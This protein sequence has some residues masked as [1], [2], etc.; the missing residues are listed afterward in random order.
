MDNWKTFR[1][2]AWLGWQTESNW[3]DPFLFA[4]YS[5]IRPIAVTLLVVLMYWFAGE[6]ESPLFGLMFLGNTLYLYVFNVLFGVSHVIQEDREHYKVL[7]YL[8][9]SPSNLYVYLIGRG[10]S[11]FLITTV[12][13]LITF[14]FGVAFLGVPVSLSTLSPLPITASFVLGLSSLVAFG[15]VMAGVSLLVARHNFY[16]GESL[17]GIFYLFCGVLFP[18]SVLPPWGEALGRLIPITYWLEGTR[19]SLLGYGDPT[20]SA[21][22]DTEVL[23]ILALSTLLLIVLSHLVF[24]GC[25]HRARERGILDRTTW[26]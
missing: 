8:Y 23:G 16:I 13:V 22:T 21:L 5:V 11:K 9:I 12:A 26:Y 1:Y 15:I 4:T 24:Q 18:L 2:A 20:L 14:A 3:T 19:R 7:K 6:K 25:V 10:V 17:A